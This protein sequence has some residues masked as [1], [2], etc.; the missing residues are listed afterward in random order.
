MTKHSATRPPRLR[1][2]LRAKL[3]SVSLTL[4]VIPW[5]GYQY[6]REM[7]TYLRHGQ[8]QALLATA[9]AVATVLHEQPE[10]FAH[11]GD[12]VQTAREDDHLYVRP[13]HTPIQL[14]GYAED[15]APYQDRAQSFGAEHILESHVPYNPASLSFREMVGSYEHYLYVMFEVT[16]DHIVYRDPNSLRLDQSDGLQIGLETPDGHFNRYLLTT[17]APGWVNAHLMP[18]DPNDT[19][20]VAPEIHIKGEWQETPKGYNLEIRIPLSMIGA[21]LAFAIADVD[22]PRTRTID[23]VIGTAGTRRLAQLGTVTVPSPTLERLLKGLEHNAGRVWVIDRNHRVLALAGQLQTDEADAAPS[24]VTESMPRRLLHALYRLILRQPATEFEDDLS[25]ASRLEGREIETALKGRPATRW[26][27]TPDRRV[28]ILAAAY[29]VWSGDQVLGAVVAEQTSNSI[30][31]LQ[32]RAME[33]LINLSVAVFLGATLILLIFASRLAARVRRLRD[34][35]E[36]AIAPDGRIQGSVRASRAGDEIGDLTRSYSAVLERLRQY[37][38]YLETIASKLSHELR[39]PMTVV[40]SSLDNLEMGTLDGEARTYTERARQGLGR[41]EGILNRMSEA[42]RLEQALQQ[43][44]QEDFDLAHVV[45][46]CVEGY[47][48]AMP[49]ASFTLDGTGAPVLMHGVPDLIAQ[50]L[51]KLVANAV[52]FGLPGTPVDIHLATAD[53][54]AVLSIANQGPPLPEEMQGN[55]FDS[56]VS[57]RDKASDEPHLGLGL[58]IVRLIAEFHGGR[59][60]ATTR[61]DPQ[62]A[63]FQVE[64]PLRHP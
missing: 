50:L 13:L 30:L 54:R 59:V 26:R 43:A 60:T 10:P 18:A 58:Y 33:N 29:P 55:L 12:V 45:S 14:D 19:R 11:Q 37:T 49:E 35:T 63:E 40:R 47:R 42:T 3:L 57:V 52:D 20:P 5:A 8:E 61:H 23:T 21:K 62:G 44:E 1:I 46:G 31:L 4:L 36:H 28:A 38:R 48:S 25:S 6:V 53:G 2:S 24:T 7:E 41:L 51:D 27:S 56:M 32:N 9:R 64:L 22:N 15:W 34:D 39:T 16:D 17:T